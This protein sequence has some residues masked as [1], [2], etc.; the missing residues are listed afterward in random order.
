MEN[1][2]G[3]LVAWHLVPPQGHRVPV[4]LSA[5]HIVGAQ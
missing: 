2:H 1:S 4:G 5:S 3:Y